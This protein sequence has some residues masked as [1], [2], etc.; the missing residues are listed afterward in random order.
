MADVKS[1]LSKRFE[2]GSDKITKM[3]QLAEQRSKG[4]L[5]SFSGVFK[6]SKLTDDEIVSIEQILVHYSAEKQEIKNDLE[7]LSLI[8]SEVRAISNQAII[9]HG[10]RIKKA[11]E[12]F[13]FYKDGAFSAWLVATYGNRQTPYNFLQ[14]F[15]FHSGFAKPLQERIENMP[16]QAIYTLASRNGTLKAKERFILGYRG[17]TKNELLTLI[18]E[19]F[20]LSAKDKRKENVASGAIQRLH[21]LTDLLERKTFTPTE[22]Q[23]EELYRLLDA[24][25]LQILKA[26]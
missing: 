9:L 23:K 22:E 24:L 26:K 14:Y 2:K 3:H 1:M 10:E 7:K 20:P 16:R 18:R 15:E 19:K 8:T 4:D 12:I 21:A 25:R 17:Q 6:V 11:Q 13:S 5:S